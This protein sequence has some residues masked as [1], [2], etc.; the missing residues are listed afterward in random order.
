MASHHVRWLASMATAGLVVTSLA[1]AS[2]PV[3]AEGNGVG[4]GRALVRI[5]AAEARVTTL[6]RDRYRIVLPASATGQWL[7]ERKGA[8]GSKRPRVGDLTAGKLAKAWTNFRYSSGWTWATVA[9]KSP[10]SKLTQGSPV[11]LERPKLTAAGVSF[12]FTSRRDM[13]QTLEGMSINVARAPRAGETP[14]AM[15]VPGPWNVYDDVWVGISGGTASSVT[16]NIYS[17]TG[18]CWSAGMTKN[19]NW[20]SVAPT[21]SCGVVTFRDGN[22]SLPAATQADFTWMTAIMDATLDLPG[23]DPFPSSHAIGAW[24]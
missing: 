9:W 22:T 10:D 16:A 6:G 20:A 13:P 18:N 3:Q 5:D 17:S 19:R 21:L 15:P 2:V 11:Q 7:G 8:D 23:C 24:T 12:D 1:C 14:R 4:K